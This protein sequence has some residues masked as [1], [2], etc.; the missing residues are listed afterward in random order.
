MFAFAL[1]L[2]LILYAV[3]AFLGSVIVCFGFR[4]GWELAGRRMRL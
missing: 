3:A 2:I 1:P 4:L